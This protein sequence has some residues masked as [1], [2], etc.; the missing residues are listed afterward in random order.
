MMKKM[1]CT[2]VPEGDTLYE[3]YHDEE[4]GV[5]VYDDCVMFEFLILESAQAGLNWRTILGKRENYRR[6]FSGFDPK[7]I[8]EFDEATL[9][10]L[11]HDPG[12]I[13]NR[14][15]IQSAVSNAKAFL[16]VQKEFGSFSK[17]FLGLVEE[18]AANK[19][20]EAPKGIAKRLKQRGFSFLGPVACYAYMQAIGIVNDHAPHCFRHKECD[21]LD[22]IQ[23]YEIS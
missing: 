17:Y 22:R 20:H 21:A 10:S 8:S 1:R 7:K 23:K 15:K 11:L 9:E 18:E 4:W 2:W 5:P 19:G 12:I 3:K 14:A 16:R 6:L 13:R